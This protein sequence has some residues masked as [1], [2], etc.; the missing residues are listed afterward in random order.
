MSNINYY[1]VIMAGG[2]GRRFWPYSRKALPK[3][4]LDFFGTGRTL[5]QQTYDRYKQII[6]PENIYITTHRD[7]KELVKNLLPE[8]D[9]SRLIV[10]EERRNTAPAIAYA[11]HVIQKVNPDATIVVAPSDHLILKMDEFKQA[12]LKGME[13]ASHS[14]KLLTLGIKPSYPETGYGYI[15]IDEKEK[16]NFYKVKTFIEK[17][18]REFAEVFVQSN[19]F[20][21]NSGIF[22]WHVNTI[23]QAF[24]EM[25]AEVCP[26]VEC[27]TPDFSACPNSSIDY[28]IMEKANNVYVQLCDFGWADIGTWGSLYDASPKDE[29]RNVI[30]NSNTL[31]Y[32]CKENIILMPEDKLAVIQDLEGY[33]VVERGNALLICK[34]DDQNAIRKFVN[35]VE[36]KFG[37][38]YS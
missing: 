13:F 4:F 28:S 32:N 1:C 37:E 6:P 29:N 31:L 21:W 8:V 9:E 38:K 26:R 35:D 11:S 7:Y 14:G 2:I 20:Y 3:Q 22:I 18:A 17:P 12:I 15:Q 10:E 23:L 33:L 24:H 27:D 30:V 36:M 16:D 5:L 25:M 34:K 19:E